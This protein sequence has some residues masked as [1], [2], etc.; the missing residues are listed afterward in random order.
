MEPWDIVEFVGPPS[1]VLRW[2]G[3]SE[4]GIIS[5]T[6]ERDGT[7]HVLWEQSTALLAWPVEWVRKVGVADPEM[8]SADGA[9]R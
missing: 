4:R 5:G 3:P 1:P 9:S 7:V 2:P 8:L 6:G